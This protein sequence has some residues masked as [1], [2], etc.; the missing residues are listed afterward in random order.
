MAAKTKNA[1]YAAAPKK[2]GR[3][4][5]I[6]AVKYDPMPEPVAPE[7]VPVAP[8]PAQAAPEPSVVPAVERDMVAPVTTNEE[9]LVSTHNPPPGGVQ[10]APT[11][12]HNPP[13]AE[14]VVSPL[15]HEAN[16]SLRRKTKTITS[17]EIEQDVHR[18]AAAMR[19]VDPEI[20]AAFDPQNPIPLSRI[21]L[22]D[23]EL[24]TSIAER[25]EKRDKVLEAIEERNARR[26]ASALRA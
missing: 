7:P 11:S 24:G 23:S 17:E 2:R 20:R 25:Q 15:Q 21:T 26:L 3:P 6:N 1:S 13:P 8:E 5:K 22:P 9:R 4:P 10:T 12:P 14:P 19:A 18:Q 16:E